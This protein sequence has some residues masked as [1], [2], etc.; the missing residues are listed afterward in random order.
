[1]ATR[2]PIGGHCDEALYALTGAPTEKLV[3]ENYETDELW[4]ILSNADENKYAMRCAVGAEDFEGEHD[5]KG[6]ASNH[7]YTLVGVLVV[8]D[9]QLVRIRNPWGHVEWNGDWCDDSDLW[10]DELKRQHGVTEANDGIFHMS[11]DDFKEEYDSVTICKIHDDYV[12]ENVKCSKSESGNGSTFSIKKKSRVFLSLT[13]KMYRQYSRDLNYYAF[14]SKIVLAKFGAD[15][16]CEL[17]G[18]ASKRYRQNTLLEVVLEPGEY[19]VWSD[20]EWDD[21]V[22]IHD[23]QLTVYSPGKTGLKA[24]PAGGALIGEIRA[25]ATEGCSMALRQMQLS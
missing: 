4:D 16:T 24:H 6:L 5:Y 7:A 18:N 19:V 3:L 1:M 25:Q 17:Y 21:D 22:P 12:F 2:L 10:T 14:K 15:K 11:I 9:T 23:Y 13:Q 8:D 20:L